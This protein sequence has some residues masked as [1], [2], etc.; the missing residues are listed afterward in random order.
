MQFRY[1]AR[2]RRSY[3]DAP[4]EVR[5]AFDR[6]LALLMSNIRHPSLRA[7]K[8][9]QSNNVWQARVNRD[10]RFYFLIQDETYILLDMM[11]HPK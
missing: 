1:T 11:A 3:Q 2:F 10:W 6:R 8:F 5:R 9:S 4:S 7:K